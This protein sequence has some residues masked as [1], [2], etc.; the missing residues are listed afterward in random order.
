MANP[1]RETRAQILFQPVFSGLEEARERAEIKEIS[2]RIDEIIRLDPSESSSKS[3][4]ISHWQK[5]EVDGLEE[6]ESAFVSF[7]RH[8]GTGEP[9]YMITGAIFL[10]G[11]PL[12]SDRIASVTENRVSIPNITSK[13]GRRD[14]EFLDLKAFVYDQHAKVV[15][16]KR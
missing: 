9:S 5:V 16:E 4:A 7:S 8:E 1:D 2:D 6:G 3:R 10:L 15:E 13:T 14:P 12:R 11:I